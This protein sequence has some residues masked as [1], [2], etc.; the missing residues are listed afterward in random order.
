MSTEPPDHSDDNQIPL[1]EDVVC[2]DELET[3]L[4]DSEFDADSEAHAPN[5]TNY[6]TVLLSIRDEIIN[7]LEF[8][9]RPLVIRSVEKII[10]EATEQL[11]QVLHAELVG[12]LEQRVH[13]L[14]KKCMEEE[15]G[16]G[17]HAAKES[18]ED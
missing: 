10:D 3:D 4:Q 18:N 2:P 15:F 12:L 8:E 11:T 7:Q 14:I 13:S 16:P 9:L 1:L 17:T 5:T 6:D